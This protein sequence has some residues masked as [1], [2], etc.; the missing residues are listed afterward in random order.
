MT[1]TTDP[2][3]AQRQ[4]AADWHGW[5]PSD[6]SACPCVVAGKPCNADTGDRLC[7]CQRHHHLLDHAR[8]WIDPEGH[9]VLTGEPYDTHDDEL[10]DLFRDLAALRLQASVSGRSLWNPGHTLL[11]TIT[12]DDYR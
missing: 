5:R 3:A 1:T 9:H 6:A 2:H 7:L 4:R 11:I 10:R 8:M 12:R